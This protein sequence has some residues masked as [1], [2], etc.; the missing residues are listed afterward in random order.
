M[1]APRLPLPLGS[2]ACDGWQEAWPQYSV[3]VRANVVSRR[4][5]SIK[6]SVVL[7]VIN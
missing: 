1:A 6:G 3:S 4:W 7:V 5:A 2:V